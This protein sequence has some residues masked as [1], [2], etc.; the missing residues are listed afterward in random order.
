ML[1]RLVFPELGDQQIG[2]IKRIVRLLD[3]IEDERGP[4]AAHQVLAFLSNLFN[5]H[6]ARDGTFPTTIVRC[7]GRSQRNAP[8]SAR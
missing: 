3:K 4:Q 8:A 1:A 2:D 5:W 7:M 6:A